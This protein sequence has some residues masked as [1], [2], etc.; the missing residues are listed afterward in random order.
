MTDLTILIYH[1]TIRSP[2]KREKH[3]VMLGEIVLEALSPM[4][5]HTLTLQLKNAIDSHT[6]C[7]ATIVPVM[8]DA[9]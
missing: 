7:G 1:R 4:H 6:T 2:G 8:E 9:K 3:E 5:A